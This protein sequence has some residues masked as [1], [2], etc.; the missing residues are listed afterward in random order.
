MKPPSKS[1]YALATLLAAILLV[2]TL[3]PLHELMLFAVSLPW[4]VV[5]TASLAGVR[6]LSFGALFAAGMLADA[7]IGLPLGLSAIS[8]MLTVEMTLRLHRKFPQD[9]FSRI[10][11]AFALMLVMQQAV[12]WLTLS[13]FAFVSPVWWMAA[14]QMLAALL[15]YPLIYVLLWPARR[16]EW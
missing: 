6:T 2:Y 16:S 11:L 8:F 15:A 9:Q 10:W 1:S 3:R 12:F 13:L 14:L 4:M 7:L 5:F